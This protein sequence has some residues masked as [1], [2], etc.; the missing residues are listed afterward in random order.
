MARTLTFFGAITAAVILTVT[1]IKG[2]TQVAPNQDQSAAGIALPNG[3]RAAT[4][5][6]W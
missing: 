5:S 3:Y 4:F 1:M 6:C 2:Q